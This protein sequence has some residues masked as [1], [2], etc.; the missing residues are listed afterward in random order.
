[1]SKVTVVASY[2]QSGGVT[3]ATIAGS[4]DSATPS[5][6]RSRWKQPAV[7]IGAVLSALASAAAVLQ[8]FGIQF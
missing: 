3:A 5:T 8:F 7:V 1:V 6:A 2:G 4:T